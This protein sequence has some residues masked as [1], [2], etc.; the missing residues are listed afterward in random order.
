M[1]SKEFDQLLARVNQSRKAALQDE[2][3]LA[4]AQSHAQELTR[5]EKMDMRPVK[6]RAKKK[7]TNAPKRFANVYEGFADGRAEGFSY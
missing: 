6:R 2:T 5:Q 7:S 1:N 3:F 4:R